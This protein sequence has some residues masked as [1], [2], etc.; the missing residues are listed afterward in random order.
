MRETSREG[1]KRTEGKS[2]WRRMEERLDG[3]RI[4]WKG[5]EDEEMERRVE[6]EEQRN[7]EKETGGRNEEIKAEGRIMDGSRVRKSNRRERKT[8]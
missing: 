3:D 5:K 4:E 1:N 6:S 8:G 7:Y 2:E